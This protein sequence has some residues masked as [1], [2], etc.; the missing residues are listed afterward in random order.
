MLTPTGI[1][2]KKIH[3]PKVRGLIQWLT[4]KDPGSPAFSQPSLEWAIS[5]QGHR[6]TGA[7]GTGMIS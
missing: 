6:L 1:N 5:A 7:A 3:Y 4:G 2:N